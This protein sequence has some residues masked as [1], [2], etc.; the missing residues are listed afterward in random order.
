MELGS[1]F[2][3]FVLSLIFAIVW[4]YGSPKILNLT[5]VQKIANKGYAGSILVQGFIVFL[6]L[7][8]ISLVFSVVDETPS[9]PSVG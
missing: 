2:L 7:I 9:L 6:F 3:L 1:L 5:S 4:N 8:A